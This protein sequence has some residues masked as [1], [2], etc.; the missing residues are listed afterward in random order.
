MSDCKNHHAVQ[1]DIKMH[2]FSQQTIESTNQTRLIC[3]VTTLTVRNQGLGIPKFAR[4]NLKVSSSFSCLLF[5]RIH[6]NKTSDYDV[7]KRR[8]MTK[9]CLLTMNTAQRNITN[10][11]F[12][13]FR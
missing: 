1:S 8:H 5:F 12:R 6:E 4:Q 7:F 3:P 11:S 9:D 10:L 2:Y 13:G